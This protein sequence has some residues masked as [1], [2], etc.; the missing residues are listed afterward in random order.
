MIPS[1]AQGIG[2]LEA[3]DRDG[4]APQGMRDHVPCDTVIV[5]SQFA[6]VVCTL[7]C[8][9]CTMCFFTAH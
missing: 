6:T 2:F 7:K 4:M 9:G 5:T 8:G 1:R 3:A